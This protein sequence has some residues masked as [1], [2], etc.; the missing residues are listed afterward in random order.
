MS[1]TK[2]KHRPR[3]MHLR[4][5]HPNA[6]DFHYHVLEKEDL[7]GKP[8][9]LQLDR[10]EQ[11]TFESDQEFTL[12]FAESPFIPAERTVLHGTSSGTTYTVSAKVRDDAVYHHWYHYT[13]IMG[14]HSTDDP[15]IVIEQF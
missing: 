11:I 15:E 14:D 3:H 1:P 10:G 7:L 9:E 5:E 12:R 13:V 2:A 4:I 6:I 8:K